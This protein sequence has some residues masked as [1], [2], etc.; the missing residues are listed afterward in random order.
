MITVYIGI[1]PLSL[2]GNSVGYEG[3]PVTE[4]GTLSNMVKHL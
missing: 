2:T 4:G 3:G 1:R